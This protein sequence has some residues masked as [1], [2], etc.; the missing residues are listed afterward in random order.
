LASTWYKEH[1]EH[2]NLFLGITQVKKSRSG[3][4]FIA[5]VCG[6]FAAIIHAESS[7]AKA[8]MGMIEDCMEGGF[9]LVACYSSTSKSGV[10][11]GTDNE[12]VGWVKHPDDSTWEFAWEHT[13]DGPF[14]T[15]NP[16]PPKAEILPRR[17]K[18][19]P[20]GQTGPSKAQEGT[21]PPF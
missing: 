7:Q 18:S 16:Q 1:P 8:L 12:V 15:P 2:K 10:M 14:T 20:M 17:A 9:T 21:E 6:K 11:F 5:E 19:K 13:V 3:D 4:W